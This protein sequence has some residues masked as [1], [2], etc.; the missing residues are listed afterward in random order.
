MSVLAQLVG[1]DDATFAVERQLDRGAEDHVGEIVVLV[2]KRVQPIETRAQPL[3]TVD[4]ACLDG[5][6]GVAERGEGDNA[7]EALPDERSAKRRRDG[8]PPLAIDAVDERG[9]EQGHAGASPRLRRHS[10]AQSPRTSMRGLTLGEGLGLRGIA[11]SN[12]G[13]NAVR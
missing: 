6:V 3:H 8:D 13:V 5:I 4:A 9:Q 1:Q 12:M 10:P 11:W 2:G 7:L